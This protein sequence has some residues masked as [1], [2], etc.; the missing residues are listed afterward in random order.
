ME[1][2]DFVA[3]GDITTDAFIK[4]KNATVDCDVDRNNCR[5]CISFGDKVPYESVTI[6]RAVGNS[7]NASVSVK[8]L[9]LNSGLVTDIGDDQNGKE[10][11]EVLNKEAV[12]TQYVIEHKGEVTNYHYV[13]WY[14]EERTILVK[15]TEYNYQFPD[16]SPPK[17]IYL[18]SLAEN[19]LPYHDQIV[20][21]LKKN[22]ETK[23]A[24]Q[25][26][27]FQIKLGYEKLKDLYEHSEL[28]FCNKNEAQRIL[29]SKE[30]DII[31][32][33]NG[34]R[35]LGPKIIIITDGPA[36]A[37]TFDA[38]EVWHMPMYPDPKPPIDRTGAGDSFSSTFIAALILGKSIPEALSWGPINSMSVVQY[39]GAQEGLVTREQLEKYLADAPENY[40]PEK[41]G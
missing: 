7:P 38:E 2:P 17:W 3:V 33:L 31:K 36:G 30:T 32:L 29:N 26:G 6:V 19:S 35:E 21:Y 23:L 18:S 27:T 12:N 14:E 13:L 9:G 8:R 41:I 39:V 1:Q 34:M 10:C 22:P 15:H 40:K 28:F 25:P 20:E 5:L 37:Y 4:I 24:F 11:L 16:I